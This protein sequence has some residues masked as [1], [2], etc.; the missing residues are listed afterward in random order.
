[1]AYNP[2]QQ[3]FEL[4]RQK[5]KEIYT[6]IEL[7]NK[8]FKVLDVI[9][10][11]IISDTFNVA[12]ESMQ[13]RS[14]S[15]DLLVTDSTFLIGGDKKIWIDKYIRVYY[16]IKNARTRE[17]SWYL[18]GIFTYLN[19]DYQCDIS[20]KYTLSLSCGDMMADYDGTKNGEIDGYTVK[21]PAGEDIRT[22]LVGLLK[23]AG[24]SRYNVTDIGKTIPHDLEFTSQVTYCDI[25]K[26]IRDLYDSWEFFFDIEGTFIWR[27]IPTGYQ[28][29]CI[30]DDIVLQ[31]L[32]ISEQQSNTFQDIYNVTEVWGQ[33]LEMSGS[34]RYA[35]DNVSY[36]DNVY[37]VTLDSGENQENV[38]SLDS[39]PDY[40]YIA[41]NIPA[42]N[43]KGAQMDLN[44]LGPIPILHDD[45]SPIRAGSLEKDKVY[46]FLYR[47]HT[48][49]S[50]AYAL[51]FLGEY[52]AYAV[53][54][55]MDP[56][57]PFSIPNIG[58]EIIQKKSCENLYSN[59]LCYNQAEYLTY[60][61]T[62]MMDTIHL[63]CV[64][65]PFLDVNQK[66][67]YTSLNS[68]QTSQYMVKSFSWSTASGTMSITLYKFLQDFSYIK[69]R[70]NTK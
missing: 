62:V 50:T 10:G 29:P 49:D 30:M 44:D 43:L 63:E 13:R 16:G 18:M 36:T 67:Q 11:Q 15:C 9:S 33:I 53:Y 66:I 31:G 48:D 12:S 55:E 39:I 26:E 8:Q 17:I 57:C 47:R 4:I 20:G 70:F 19:A 58:Y 45:R 6:R 3:D 69:K 60:K 14:Y 41:V 56:Q 24:I 38:D 1:M 68:G 65:I 7:L 22:S 35:G 32:V 54:R 5:T 34:D 42:E 46:T 59:D 61:S 28:E 64:F 40:A 23:Q 51:Y 52:Q 21:I 37:H 27:K 25:W 2:T